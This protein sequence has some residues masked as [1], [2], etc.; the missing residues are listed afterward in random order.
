MIYCRSPNLDKVQAKIVRFCF[1][2]Q[3]YCKLVELCASNNFWHNQ[4]C[5]SGHNNYQTELKKNVHLVNQ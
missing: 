3:K 4:A 5:E 2:T 1:E